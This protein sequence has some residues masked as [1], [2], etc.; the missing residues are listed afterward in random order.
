MPGCAWHAP[1][2]LSSFLCCVCSGATPL[3]LFTLEASY[4]EIVSSTA[5]Q[6]PF[7]L[8]PRDCQ[9]A[10][11]YWLAL[12]YIEAGSQ[13]WSLLCE[14]SYAFMLCLC[15]CWQVRVF[16]AQ[17]ILSPAWF[18]LQSM[19]RCCN[20]FQAE[21]ASHAPL[22]V[23]LSYFQIMEI[24]RKHN[25]THMQIFFF[26]LQNKLIIHTLPRLEM[27]Q[28]SCLESLCYAHPF[29]SKTWSDSIAGA[30]LTREWVLLQA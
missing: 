5:W 20:L 27:A 19:E 7:I 29:Q 1:Y 8:V 16:M 15:Q 17:S 23:L 30:L 28:C 24:M 21:W 13:I 22:P 14:S 12:H 18:L 25:K 4:F 6:H 2:K 26:L 10:Q 9:E 11:I 3:V